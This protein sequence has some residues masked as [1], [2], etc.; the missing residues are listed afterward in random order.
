MLTIPVTFQFSRTIRSQLNKFVFQTLLLMTKDN[1]Q[2]FVVLYNSSSL[3]EK[4]KFYILKSTHIFWTWKIL[5]ISLGGFIS[6]YS[7]IR[8]SF[9]IPCL[10]SFLVVVIFF[11]SKCILVPFR[12][13][14]LFKTK[15][16]TQIEKMKYVDLKT[17]S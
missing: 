16:N 7:R 2:A 6:S 1:H 13:R 17:K 9:N 8:R 3:K 11:Y 15:E 4:K 12:G 14:A 10:E 5:Y